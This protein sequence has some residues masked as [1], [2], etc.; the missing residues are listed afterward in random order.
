MAEAHAW[1]CVFGSGCDFFGEAADL[2]GVPEPGSVWPPEARA[3]A[4]KAW[5]AAARAAWGRAG[6]V[7]VDT[8]H[9]AATGEPWALQEFGMPAECR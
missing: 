4:E 1:G 2:C 5:T 3:E 9:D 7:Y 6:R 8:L